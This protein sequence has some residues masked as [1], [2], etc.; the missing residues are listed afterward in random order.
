MSADRDK[1]MFKV[2]ADIGGTFTD[3][4]FQSDDGILEKRKVRTTPDDF[5]RAIVT[6]VTDFLHEKKVGGDIISDIMH[7]TTVA[8]NAIL[9]RQG[10][11]TALVTTEGFRDVLELRRIRIPFSYDLSWQKPEPLADREFRFEVRERVSAEGSVLT[12]LEIETINPA[13]EKIKKEGIESVAVSLLHSYRDPRHEKEIASRLRQHIPDLYVSLSH[14]ILPEVRE[15]ERTST[16]VTNAYVAPL[17][18]RYL[19]RLK[20]RFREIGTTAPILVM[21]SAGGLISAEA[22]SSLAV[23]IIESGPAAGVVGAAGLARQCGCENVITLDMGGTTTKASIIEDGEMLRAN[24]YEV[25]SEISVSSRLVRG[26]GYLLRMPVIDIS[27]VGAGGGSIARID[28]A[29][30][31]R[32]GPRSAGSV[33]GPACYR[34]GNDQPTV[35]DANLVLGYLAPDSLAGGSLPVDG[36]L[37]VAAVKKYTG[38][39]AG[40]SVVEAAWGIYLVTNS[41]M[42]RAIKSVS[43]ERGRDPR[44]FNMIA[45]GGA[46]PL[47]AAAIARE[48]GIRRTL[49]PPSPGVF[50][51]FG[52][53]EAPIEQHAARSVLCSTEEKDQHR[54]VEAYGRLHDEILA[55]FRA[56]GIDPEMVST[57]GSAD[58]RYHGQ[59]AELAVPFDFNLVDANSLRE[60]EEKFEAEHE[61]TFGHRGGVRK[62][63]FVTAR[64]VGTLHHGQKFSARWAEDRVSEKGLEKKRSCYFGP[65]IGF[66][67]TPVISRQD[68]S[69]TSRAGPVLV[70]EYDTTVVVPPGFSISSDINGNIIIETGL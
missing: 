43:I 4:V 40:L 49:I 37:A 17:V 16:T 44:D 34:N 67:E 58:I 20:R 6:G 22:A 1:V 57:T 8:T 2:A 33:P 38:D 29:G 5:S 21:Q 39:P 27:E 36:S 70:H 61:R 32:V 46:G 19:G 25:G 9:E 66:V 48:L 3:I 26:S 50:S 42:V 15:F 35:T 53:L 23:T 65:D 56:E 18:A 14:E 68:L 59:S 45:F 12:P 63:D 7:A 13:I 60:V 52:L 31:L 41:N 30:A 10:A 24:E 62:F 55:R 28:D 69:P 64:M 54:I 11:K 51:A 47:H